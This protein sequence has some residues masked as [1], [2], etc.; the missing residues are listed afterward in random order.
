MKLNEWTSMSIKDEKFCNK[1]FIKHFSLGYLCCAT[2]EGA[3]SQINFYKMSFWNFHEALCGSCGCWR[4]KLNTVTAGRKERA[5]GLSEIS[6]FHTI[7]NHKFLN[8]LLTLSLLVT[9]IK[10]FSLSV[11]KVFKTKV[12][13]ISISAAFL[14]L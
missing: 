1:N 6:N 14:S 8:Y 10:Y 7:I 2:S 5:G 13:K 4:K 12:Q 11:E 9:A 3:F